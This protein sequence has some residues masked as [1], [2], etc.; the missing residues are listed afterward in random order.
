MFYVHISRYI[1]NNILNDVRRL[2]F[3]G[4]CSNI[5]IINNSVNKIKAN[6]MSINTTDYL[7]ISNNIIKEST[8]SAIYAINCRYA[9]INCN[10]LFENGLDGTSSI[11]A[12]G[13]CIDTFANN[14][15]IINTSIIGLYGINIYKTSVEPSYEPNNN[16]TSNN[17]YKGVTYTENFSRDVIDDRSKSGI[18]I[19]GYQLLT[20][21][22]TDKTISVTNVSL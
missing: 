9:N 5:S 13:S 4:H 11:I 8:Q 18:M 20:T 14:N 17:V 19:N 10:A 22:K 2:V 6:G 7:T 21:S 15:F 3:T 1:S 16:F 12:L